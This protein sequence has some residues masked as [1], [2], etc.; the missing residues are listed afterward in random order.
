MPPVNVKK[1]TAPAAGLIN[2]GDVAST[3]PNL[4]SLDSAPLYERVKRHMSEAILVG[5]WQPGMVLPSE[6]ALAQGFGIAVGTVRRAMSDLVAEGLLS[7]RRKTG[8]VV[9]GRAPH[10]SLRFFF[11]YFRL[12][13]ADGSLVKSTSRF[14]SI[15]GRAA[16]GEEAERLQ[17]SSGGVI[18][19]HRIRHADG[20]PVMHDKLLF[21]EERVPGLP[22]EIEA[23][24]SLLYLH[25]LERY[26]IRVSAVR[27]QITADLASDEDMAL[28]GL[29]QREAVLTIDEVAYDQAGLPTILGVHRAC[30]RNHVYINEVR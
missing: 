8:T 1:T 4:V 18:A 24:P 29:D 20:R 14:L 26:G 12:H 27:E 15:E 16:T 11:Q 23:L 3:L 13:R 9:T 25:L 6:T 5:E 30:T 21:A 10:H 17:I 7:R 22:R 19:I 28:L 2:G